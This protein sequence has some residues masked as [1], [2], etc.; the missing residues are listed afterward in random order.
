MIHEFLRTYIFT[1]DAWLLKGVIGS[2]ILMIMLNIVNE[3]PEKTYKQIMLFT[4]LVVLGPISCVPIL[5][6]LAV[7]FILWLFE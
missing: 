5:I 6:T 2:I 3:L 1:S 7:I 4:I